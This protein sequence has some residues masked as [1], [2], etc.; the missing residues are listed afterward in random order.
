MDCDKS[1]LTSVEGGEMMIEM[2][3]IIIIQ[4]LY[5]YSIVTVHCIHNTD[6]A[7]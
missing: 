1:L 6:M 7:A 2:I 4:H 5:K 3:E